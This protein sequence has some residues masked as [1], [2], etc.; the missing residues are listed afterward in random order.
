VALE[1]GE[2]LQELLDNLTIGIAE[3]SPEH[4]ILSTWNRWQTKVTEHLLPQHQQVFLK[5]RFHLPQSLTLETL[6]LH[7]GECLGLQIN[8][9]RSLLTE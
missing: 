5:L 7:I 3:D 4:Q 2:I 8:Y 9:L 6:R 1:D